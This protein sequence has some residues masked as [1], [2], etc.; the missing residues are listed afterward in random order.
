MMIFQQ[1]TGET[2]TSNSLL[3][4]FIKQWVFMMVCIKYGCICICTPVAVTVF[5]ACEYTYRVVG[6]VSVALSRCSSIKTSGINPYNKLRMNVISHGRVHH[7]SI[8]HLLVISHGF[9]GT[10]MVVHLVK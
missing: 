1:M 5:F 3:P 4:S 10:S 9:P 8:L 6:A 7:N 2:P